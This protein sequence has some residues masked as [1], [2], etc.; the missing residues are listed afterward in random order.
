MMKRNPKSEIRNSKQIRNPN[1]DLGFGF[2]I[3]FEFRIS[4]FGFRIF[5]IVALPIAGAVAAIENATILQQQGPVTLSVRAKVER[6]Q[7]D[8]RLADSLLL[9]ITVEGTAQLEVKRSAIQASEVIKIR[10]RQAPVITEHKDGQRW[11]QTFHLE[12]LVP[13]NH[14]VQLEPLEYQEKPGEWKT[15]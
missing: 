14:S 13:G 3:C 5:L 2:R 4:A 12:P 6:A 15:V 7:I 11:Q 8:L 1:I 9:T 10:G